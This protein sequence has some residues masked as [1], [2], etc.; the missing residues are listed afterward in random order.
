MYPK[1]SR[2]QT[3][4]AFGLT[5]SSGL[6]SGCVS[7][8]DSGPESGDLEIDNGDTESHTV[9]VVVEK[10]STNSDDS[11]SNFITRTPESTP[12]WAQESRFEV[13]ASETVKRTDYITEPGAFFVQA[14]LETGAS[15][16]GWIGLYE[17]ASGGVAEQYLDITIK[18]DRSLTVVA[19][20][21]GV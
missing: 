1:P 4:Q 6:L 13:D 3:L 12:I 21:S 5:C 17:S 8:T 20:Q 9:T 2:R 7:N 15:T 14:Q 16:Q 10:I 11:Y 19:P 18:S